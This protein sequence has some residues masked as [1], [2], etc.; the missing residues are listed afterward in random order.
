[1]QPIPLYLS[2]N[3]E[4][5]AADLDE[6]NLEL[7]RLFARD[8]Y[9]VI[10]SDLPDM[11]GLAAQVVEELDGHHD[12]RHRVQDAWQTCEAV[13]T[14]AT[15]GK[16][17]RLLEMLYGRPAFPFQTLNFN[18]GSRQRTHSDTLHFDSL[19]RG[20][21]AGVW[22]ALED[23]DADNGPLQYYPGSHRLPHLELGELGPRDARKGG[24]GTYGFY[25]E[26]Y[27][28]AIE[29]LVEQQ[30]FQPQF[31]HLKKGQ[32]LI[33]AAN[34]LHGGAP[35]N[36]AAR[37]RHSQVTHYYFDDCAWL[38]PMGG[39]ALSGYSMFR[40]PIDIRTGERR[41]G[42]YGQDRIGLRH[43][44]WHRV[45]RTASRFLGRFGPS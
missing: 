6:G 37:T 5:I 32:A 24:R 15:H 21:M 11:D 43:L 4:Q 2:P 19:P 29:A 12:E 20:F 36:D 41:V 14:I 31:G 3:F 34:L 30:R 23:V 27:E 38:T 9:V 17:L 18:E 44:A 26:V 33:W 40:Q 13:R 10:D 1:M 16:F 25:H 28:P 45:R 7:L 42:T 39:D 35:V 22:V 8:G